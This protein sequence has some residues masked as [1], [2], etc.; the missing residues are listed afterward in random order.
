MTSQTHGR[1]SIPWATRAAGEQG[2]LTEFIILLCAVE[3]CL[4]CMV[5]V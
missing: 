4:H 3:I 5:T 2:H 1:R